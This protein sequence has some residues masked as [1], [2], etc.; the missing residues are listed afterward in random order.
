MLSVDI[1]SIYIFSLPS[2]T[3]CSTIS[4]KYISSRLLSYNVTKCVSPTPRRCLSSSSR[5]CLSIIT[6]ARIHSSWYS[7]NYLCGVNHFLCFIQLHYRKAPQYHRLTMY[8]NQ[9]WVFFIHNIHLYYCN[10]HREQ[11]VASLTL[12]LDLIQINQSIFR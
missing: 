8:P 1:I 5:R 9:L 12:V 10:H 6:T 4:N 3:N 7:K 2:T 11:L